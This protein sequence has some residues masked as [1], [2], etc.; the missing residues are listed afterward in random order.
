LP[1][2]EILG[3]LVPFPTKGA[4]E[5]PDP[6]DWNLP[7]RFITSQRGATGV[8]RFTKMTKIVLGSLDCLAKSASSTTGCV[9]LIA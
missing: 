9:M 3:N 5:S 8:N 1:G 4:K 2:A 6:F 7:E